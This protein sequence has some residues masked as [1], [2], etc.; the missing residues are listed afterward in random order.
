MVI[1]EFYRTRSDGVE[2]QRSYSSL[3]LYIERDGELYEE[4]IDP[5]SENRTYT[6]TDVEINPSP[7]S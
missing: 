1:T 4:A 6:E 7:Q 3:G 5:I 2:L